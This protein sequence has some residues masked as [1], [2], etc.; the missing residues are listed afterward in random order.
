MDTRV[1]LKIKVKSLAEEARII[2]K[3]TK[4]NYPSSIKNG[5]YLHRV[6]VVRHEARHTHLALGFLKGR[7]Y[8]QMEPKL[9]RACEPDWKKVRKMVE[10][11]GSPLL[12]W[13]YNTESY[14]KYG[15]RCE[16]SKEE[17]LARFDQWVQTAQTEEVVQ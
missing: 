8:R 1:Y 9:T 10:K 2:K 17:V 13:D 12:S 4:G 15:E 3:E 11:Y 7:S 5:L 6:N 14:R 16:K